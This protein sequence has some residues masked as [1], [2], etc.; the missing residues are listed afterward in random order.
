M[1]QTLDLERAFIARV[2]YRRGGVKMT[3]LYVQ[4][5]AAGISSECFSDPECRLVWKA[6]E[7]IFKTPDFENMSLFSLTEKANHLA[8]ISKQKEIASIEVTK[9]FFDVAMKPI[10]G[11]ETLKGFCSLILNNFFRR[12]IRELSEVMNDSMVG[13]DSPQAA[14]SVF[15]SR[16]SELMGSRTCGAKI[17]PKQEGEVAL[18][19]YRNAFH[20]VQEL[21]E[22]NYTPG[23]PMPW[24][25]LSYA[26]NGF[27]PALCILAA[28]PGVGKTSMAVNMVRFWTDNGYKVVFNSLDMSGREL[29][30]RQISEMS[31]ISSRKMKF[32][33]SVKETFEA[34]YK[35]MEDAVKRF[36]DLEEKGIYRP[37]AEYDID[38]LKA[39]CRILKDQGEIDVLVVDYIQQMKYDGSDRLTDVQK[40]TRI[41]Q[42]LHSITI[43]LGIPVLALSQLN[44]SNDKEEREARLSDL[45]G[46]GAIEQ[47]ASYVILLE[48]ATKVRKLWLESQT[49]P[50]QYLANPERTEI[51]KSFMPVWVTLAKSRDGD[52][53]EKIPFVVIQNKYAWY[54]AD[55]EADDDFDKFARV[56][57]DWRH[58]PIEKVWERNGALIRSD[59]RFD[60]EA[61]NRRIASAKTDTQP[62]P[63]KNAVP[64]ESTEYG[65][66][67]DDPD[68]GDVM[69]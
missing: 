1:D 44:R 7:E 67:T 59:S 36:A 24:R 61:T 50:T 9:A 69:I 3:E 52:A 48:R 57:D 42:M 60:I 30:R 28:R 62:P 8:S 29:I 40:V 15:H 12:R 11:T 14:L 54:Q 6:A 33:K 5:S 53:E 65:V 2:F 66:I 22:S 43:E 41:S 37:I 13:G 23:I 4:A 21:G 45:R 31:R 47:D 32:G 16:A 35:A 38:R 25:K 18:A 39:Y 27:E 19:E 17:S 63:P 10:D 64:V 56:W 55:Y 58:D 68:I 46:S 34:D 20:H 26:M 49:A 51:L